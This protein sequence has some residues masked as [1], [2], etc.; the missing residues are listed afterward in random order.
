[1]LWGRKTSTTASCRRIGRIA[2][3]AEILAF[4]RSDRAKLLQ[5]VNIFVSLAAALLIGPRCTC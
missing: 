4:D 1:M 5:R 3:E 2:M